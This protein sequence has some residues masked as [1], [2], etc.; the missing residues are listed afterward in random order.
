LRK[1]FQCIAWVADV[2]Q[3]DNFAEVEKKALAIGAEKV[4]IRI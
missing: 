2:G 1:G 4:I 3:E